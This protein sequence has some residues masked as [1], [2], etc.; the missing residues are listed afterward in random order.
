MSRAAAPS[1]TI[2]LA[3][4]PRVMSWNSGDSLPTPSSGIRRSKR[5][6]HCPQNPVPKT[7]LCPQAANAKWR[8]TDLGVDS[9]T[10]QNLGSGED[11]FGIANPQV[12]GDRL[13][14]N[15][16]THWTADAQL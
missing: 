10:A 12:A 13:D 1:N 11:C 8:N 3:G 9:G 2:M 5:S 7:R 15:V 16:G 6:L 14:G 4:P